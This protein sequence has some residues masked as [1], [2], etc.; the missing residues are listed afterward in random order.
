MLLILSIYIL[1]YIGKVLSPLY[2]AATSEALK[3]SAF[4]KEWD[5]DSRLK[6]AFKEAKTLLTKAINLTYPDPSAPLALSTDASKVAMG[7]TLDQWVDGAWQP[8]GMWSKSSLK[9]KTSYLSYR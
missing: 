3:G 7:A 1:K 5:K 2:K 6:N 4:K 9:F 8:L